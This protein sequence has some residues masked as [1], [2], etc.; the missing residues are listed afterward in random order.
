[1]FIFRFFLIIFIKIFINNNK[2]FNF[3]FL[4]I[5]K[6]ILKVFDIIMNMIK[7]VSFFIFIFLRIKKNLVIRNKFKLWL[8]FISD[9]L[10]N[11]R[12]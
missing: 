5:R 10:Y 12:I 1:M 3:I 4:K 8:K 7:V 2:V 9:V 11:V 6:V